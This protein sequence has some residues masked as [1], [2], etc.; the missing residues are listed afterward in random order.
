MTALSTATGRG[1]TL[2]MFCKIKNYKY[3]LQDWRGL[4]LGKR[5][6]DS[7]TL[8]LGGGRFF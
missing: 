1:L 5:L 7:K 4:C 3:V 8:F 2:N 6:T